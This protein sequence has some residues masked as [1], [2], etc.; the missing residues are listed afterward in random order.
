M[1]SV[2]KDWVVCPTFKQEM[3]MTEISPLRRCM[4][5]DMTLPNLCQRRND[6][7]WMR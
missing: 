3:M 4:I 2:L 1:I 5:D 6:R 7:V